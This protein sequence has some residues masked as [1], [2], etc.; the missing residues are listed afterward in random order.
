MNYPELA[1]TIIRLK[2]EDLALRDHLLQNGLLDT[3]YNEDMAALHSRNAACLDDIIEDI[4]YPTIDQVGE[5]ASE[6]AWLVIQHAIG[7]PDFM[8]K[9]ARLL[10][11]AV[12]ENKASA[13]NLAYLTDRIATFEG[14][15][16]LYG[17][18]FDWDDKGEMSPKPFDDLARV[19]ERRKNIGLNTLE[20]QTKLMRKQVAIEKQLPPVDIKEREHAYEEW[21]R[22]VGWVK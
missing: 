15:V 18:A 1:A 20:E 9:C 4:G 22:K 17:T 5:E 10:A 8:K 13:K 19:N 6:A 3:G 11:K 7:A 21:R 2:N 16:Q 14:Q 12:H